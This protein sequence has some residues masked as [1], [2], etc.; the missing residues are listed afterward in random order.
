MSKTSSEQIQKELALIQGNKPVLHP[1]EVV[2]WAKNNPESALYASFEWNDSEAA[3]EYRLWQARR[4]IALNIVTPEGERKT[5]SLV[6]DRNKGG[7]YRQIEDVVRVP[8][9]RETML[10]D[11]LNELRRV[12]AK[13]KQLQELAAVFAEIDKLD[14]PRTD[15]EVA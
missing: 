10:R 2:E 8:E 5:V 9:L 12:R 3:R 11:A 4:L 7:G 6:V 1:H 13:Y 14:P 15:E